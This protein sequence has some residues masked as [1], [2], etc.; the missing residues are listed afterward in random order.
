MSALKANKMRWFFIL[1]GFLL[2][3]LF[4]VIGVF[5]W[6]FS[7]HQGAGEVIE[8]GDLHLVAN[9]KVEED[10]WQGS[11]RIL[12]EQK[13]G[14]NGYLYLVHATVGN[15]NPSSRSISLYV[16]QKTSVRGIIRN[17]AA[18]YTFITSRNLLNNRMLVILKKQ[19]G[20]PDLEEGETVLAAFQSLGEVAE[21]NQDRQA[22]VLGITR[23]FSLL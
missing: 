9:Q 21:D 7:Y 15:F 2:F 17:N 3:S 5:I 13:A 1:V 22:K 12:K 11:P 20:L 10:D 6:F 18:F 14:R 19:E 4:L 23:K 16:G 8:I